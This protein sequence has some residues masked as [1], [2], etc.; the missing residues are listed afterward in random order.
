M[1]RSTLRRHVLILMGCSH[2][3]AQLILTP[4]VNWAGLIIQKILGNLIG[5]TAAG[6]QTLFFFYYFHDERP[7]GGRVHV[8]PLFSNWGGFTATVT[9]D[10]RRQRPSW[11]I[12][13]PAFFCFPEMN[14]C[15]LTL[16]SHM[17]GCGSGESRGGS[18]PSHCV[19]QMDPLLLV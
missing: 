13:P 18:D 3:L 1:H 14:I 17:L 5:V 11:L 7:R 6:H 19:G 15:R 8:K 2:L 10:P 9:T 4:S 12:L 16:S